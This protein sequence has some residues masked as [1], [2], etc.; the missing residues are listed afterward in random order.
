M[1]GGLGDQAPVEEACWA[2]GQDWGEMVT[3]GIADDDAGLIGL[4]R[5]LDGGGD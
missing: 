4:G 2:T 5:M 1:G 3:M